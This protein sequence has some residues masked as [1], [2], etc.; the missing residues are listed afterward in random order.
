MFWWKVH[1]KCG[2][3]T[4]FLRILRFNY[5]FCIWEEAEG[6]LRAL[7]VCSEC[8]II[9]W[10]KWQWRQDLR[11][12]LSSTFIIMG[13]I[14][15]LILPHLLTLFP[16]LILVVIFFSFMHLDI[17]K[18]KYSILC[19]FLYDIL[20]LYYTNFNFLTTNDNNYLNSLYIFHVYL[21]FR[22]LMKYSGRRVAY[23]F[24]ID[25]LHLFFLKRT[26]WNLMI[27]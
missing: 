20:F 24:T 25:T 27:I 7:T 10:E 26:T 1:S 13:T 6:I 8:Y 12:H 18:L 9:W 19:L 11:N 21:F 14:Y 2:R 5:M 4:I 23:V 15:L 3:C 22:R 16:V 17:N